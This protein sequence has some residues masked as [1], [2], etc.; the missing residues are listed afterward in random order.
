MEWDD[1]LR[2]Y[3]GEFGRFQKFTALLAILVGPTF[4]M[5]LVAMTFLAATPEHHCRVLGNSSSVGHRYQ[6]EGY[7][8]SV[9][10]ENIGGTW[11][12]SSCLMFKESNSTTT[13]GNESTA[14]THGWEYDRTI[15]QSTIVTEYDLVCSTA[16][17]KGLGQSSFMAGT[18]IGGVFFGTLS[19]RFGRRPTTV[20]CLLLHLALSIGASFTSDYVS[21]IVL[22][23]LDGAAANGLY[24]TAFVLGT[25]DS[26]M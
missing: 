11:K 5:S 8:F 3:L 15:Y 26:N 10:L 20:L 23:A 17:L 18:S 13:P 25:F 14:C 19:D 1:L 16:W 2:E 22:R 24:F 4:G 12:P 6:A 9:P 7:N 21:F